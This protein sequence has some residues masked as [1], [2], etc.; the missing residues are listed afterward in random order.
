MEQPLRQKKIVEGLFWTAL[1]SSWVTFI[2][3]FTIPIGLLFWFGVLIYFF[4]KRVNLKWYLLLCSSWTVVPLFSFAS[5]TKD[6]FQGKAAIEMVGL[7]DEEFYNLDPE[8][9]VWNSSSG[10][11]VIG[12]EPFTQI[13]NNLAVKFWTKMLGR[14]TGVYKGVYP[15]RQQAEEL[16]KRGEQM[17]LYRGVDTIFLSSNKQNLFL[18]PGSFGNLQELEKVTTAKAFILNR[19]CLLLQAAPDAT[20]TVIILADKTEGIPFAKY[21]YYKSH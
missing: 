21:F 13:P 3:F 17:N 20:K 6:Y 11:I 10:C 19:E 4:F 7:P 8:L 14:Q 16:V 15:T 12:F 9:R 18:V 5:G 1:L 2:F